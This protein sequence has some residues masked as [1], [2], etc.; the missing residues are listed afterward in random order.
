MS[1]FSS[2]K[3]NEVSLSPVFVETAVPFFKSTTSYVI[4]MPVTAV[5]ADHVATPRSA[6][7]KPV[8]VPS[9]AAVM[10]PTSSKVLPSLNLKFLLSTRAKAKV[11]VTVCSPTFAES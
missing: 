9:C 3:S 4:V 5:V 6:H 1:L 8:G 11:A 10:R 7:C 2:A